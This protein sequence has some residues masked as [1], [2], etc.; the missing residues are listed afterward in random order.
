VWLSS[1]FYNACL[2]F[3]K[4]SVLALYMRL[5]DPRLRRRAIFMAAVVGCQASAN[6]LTCLFQCTPVKAAWDLTITNGRCVNIDAFY[7]ANAAFTYILPVDLV[8]HLQMPTKQKFGLALMLG[9]GLL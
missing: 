6:V 4:I 1:V 9:L 2:G 8:R 3:I 7:L 5:G